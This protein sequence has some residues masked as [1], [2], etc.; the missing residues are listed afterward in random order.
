MSIEYPLMFTVGDAISGVGYLAMVQLAGRAL[1]VHEED[2]RWWTYG[3]SPGSLA[4]S[5][6]TPQESY[7]LFRQRYKEVLFDLADEAKDFDQFSTLVRNFF[8]AKDEVELARWESALDKLRSGKCAPEDPFSELPRKKPSEA[9][10]SVDVTL[11]DQSRAKPSDN[12]ADTYELAE[13][14]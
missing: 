2:G 8:H 10:D 11:V 6:L 9:P 14:A 5:G 4:E 7:L 13:A 3:V 1:M 12:V